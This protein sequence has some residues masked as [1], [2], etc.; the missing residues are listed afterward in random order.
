LLQSSSKGAVP[1]LWTCFDLSFNNGA[2]L[3]A[4]T[5]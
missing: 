1:F 3:I 5:P 4:V 2:M